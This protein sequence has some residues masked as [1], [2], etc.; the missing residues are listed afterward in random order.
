M[1]SPASSARP[2]AAHR[3]ALLA[4]VALVGGVASACGHD[5][6]SADVADGDVD[7][8]VDGL[9]D[10]VEEDGSAPD[11]GAADEASEDDGSP[12]DGA[13]DDGGEPPCEMGAR[14]CAGDALEACAE[15]GWYV[16]ELCPLGCHETESRCRVF[17]PLNLEP[18]DLLGTGSTFHLAADSMVEFSTTA[19]TP[20]FSSESR[21]VVVGGGSAYCVLTTG[22]LIVEGTL[23][24]SGGLPLIFVARGTATIRGTID[25]SAVGTQPGPAGG[26]G[27]AV[28]GA[29]GGGPGGGR[30][31]APLHDVR[32]A[33]GAR[34]DRGVVGGRAGR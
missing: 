29:D 34:G 5:W 23:R 17:D 13:A 30:G 11:D 31:G 18:A 19:C 28:D 20:M 8:A 21:I 2:A 1:S 16:V 25:L 22:E 14:R 10:L 33:G 6:S 9:G 24:V 15:D 7:A 32:R 12:D 3:L 27:G 26:A 4:V